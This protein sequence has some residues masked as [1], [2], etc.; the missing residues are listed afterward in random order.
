M[1]VLICSEKLN[2]YVCLDPTSTILALDTTHHNTILGSNL[3]N[4]LIKPVLNW[5]NT[6]LAN[7]VGVFVEPE[8]C[9]ANIVGS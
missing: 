7:I 1:L 5:P 6:C 8:K 9:S 3:S 4:T 2:K